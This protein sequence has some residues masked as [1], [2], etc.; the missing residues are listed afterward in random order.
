MTRTHRDGTR[1]YDLGGDAY[2]VTFEDGDF[3]MTEADWPT[4]GRLADVINEPA[5]VFLFDSVTYEAVRMVVSVESPPVRVEVNGR[6]CIARP[7]GAYSDTPDR[8]TV[9]WAG[10]TPWRKVYRAGQARPRRARVVPRRS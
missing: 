10:L 5:G 9:T 8:L 1:H 6:W 4:S 2:T 7:T 3:T